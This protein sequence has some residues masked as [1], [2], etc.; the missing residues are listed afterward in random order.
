MKCGKGPGENKTDESGECP[1][2]T[3]VSAN[4]LNRGFNGGR[5][6]WVIAGRYN[7]N[8]PVCSIAKDLTSCAECEFYRHVAAEE[9]LLSICRSTGYLLRNPDE[10]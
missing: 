8:N 10:V 2:T 6:C 1:V 5:I 3:K 7:G 9:G 4:G